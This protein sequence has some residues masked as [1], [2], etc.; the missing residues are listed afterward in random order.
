MQP[1]KLLHQKSIVM[2][3]LFILLAASIL[4]V[5]CGSKTT[6]QNASD[7]ASDAETALPEQAPSLVG[8]NVHIGSLCYNLYD[9]LTAEVRNSDSY[10]NFS[11]ALT[12]PE[13]VDYD[14]QTYRV[15]S[16]G[17]DAFYGCSGLTSV[18]IPNSV[19]SIGYGAFRYCTGLTSPV[20]NEHVF[21]YL[22]PSYRGAYAVP[23]GI[24]QI[25][26]GAFRDCTGLTSVTIPN[27]VTSI[28]DAAFMDCT[29]LTSVTIP[30]SVTGIGDGAFKWC[31]G[32][33]SVTIPNSVTNIGRSAFEDCS[34]LT[35]VTIPNSV[36]SI[37]DRAF[38]GCTNLQIMYE[39]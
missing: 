39:E 14:S 28:G 9:N 13:T 1:E 34:G 29:G 21:A 27:S 33:T 35:S 17:D 38:E 30:N 18:T 32:L 31:T 23:K 12:I 6:E 37:G 36:T 25:A 2:R 22:P 5:A 15:T 16:I 26:G 11:D 4:F 10:K 24:S 8:Q 7:N 3:K 20:Y 19:T